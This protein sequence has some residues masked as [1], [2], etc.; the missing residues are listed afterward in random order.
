MNLRDLKKD[1]IVWN[2]RSDSAGK[3]V[4]IDV[5]SVTGDVLRIRVR[6]RLR[7]GWQHEATWWDAQSVVCEAAS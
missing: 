6:R 7:H 4:R 5:D 3:V 1:D 2:R